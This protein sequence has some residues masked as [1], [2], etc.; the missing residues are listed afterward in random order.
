MLPCT[1]T[2]FTPKAVRGTKKYSTAGGCTED[3]L[4][5]LQLPPEVAQSIA[6][7][8]NLGVARN[9]WNTYRTAQ[10]MLLKCAKETKTNMEVPMTERKIIIFIDWLARIR[11]LKGTTIDSYLSGIRQLH[12]VRGI[13]PPE[14][15]TGLV[16]LV[17]KG[18][19]NRDGIN[20]RTEHLTGRLPM[21]TNVMLLLQR[22]IRD[23]EI[24]V[25][26]KELVWAVATL[27]FAGAFRISELLC[28]TESS[29]DPDFDL[30]GKNVTHSQDSQ[31]KTTIHIV[32]KCPKESKSKTVTTVDVF[33]NNGPL[34]P[35]DAMRKWNKNID[36]DKN[37]PVFRFEN[38]T[39]LTGAK[40]NILLDKTIGRYTDKS[41]GKF[42]THSFRIGLA[43]ELARMG[44]SDEEIKI[45]GRWSSRAFEAYIRLKRTKRRVVAKKIRALDG[46]H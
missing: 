6:S 36:R 43:S 44:F 26:D 24:S 2:G 15:R 40:M 25:K 17:L 13:P 37:L 41:I 42:T 21:T 33:E 5:N 34:C 14:I 11:N 29:F 16:K 30:V 10:T 9:T 1:G 35:I 20:N 4:E 8:G 28:K 12:V 31:G 38:G 32:L 27:A 39:P 45:A 22:L 19:N 46:K 18:L 3:L 23:L 7:L